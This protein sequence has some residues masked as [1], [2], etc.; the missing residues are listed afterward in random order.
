MHGYSGGRALISK[1]VHDGVFLQ[2]APSA[3]QSCCRMQGFTTFTPVVTDAWCARALSNANPA[4]VER[5]LSEVC[6]SM[7]VISCMDCGL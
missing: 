5:L 2:H 4:P 6:N 1:P 7:Q 3:A